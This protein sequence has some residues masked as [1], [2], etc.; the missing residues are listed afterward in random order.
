MYACVLGVPGEALCLPRVAWSLQ[1]IPPAGISLV[2]GQKVRTVHADMRLNNILARRGPS[3]WEIS[4]VDFG[5]SG[6]HGLS[7]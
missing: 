5:W 4:F 6:I 7:K 3:G 1:V 2:D